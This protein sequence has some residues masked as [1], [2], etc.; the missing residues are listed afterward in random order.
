MGEYGDIASRAAFQKDLEKAI[1]L[2]EKLKKTYSGSPSFESISL[3]L[4]EMQRT[5]DARDPSED[6]RKKIDVGLVVVRELEG[7]ED[8]DVAALGKL[9]HPLAA[10]YEDWPTDEVAAREAAG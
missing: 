3:Q 1:A 8:E 2:T 7:V 10:F 4:A 5:T 6:E 9:V